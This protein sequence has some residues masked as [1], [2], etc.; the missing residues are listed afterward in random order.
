MASTGTNY[1]GIRLRYCTTDM[2]RAELGQN[3][4]GSQGR[5]CWNGYGKALFDSSDFM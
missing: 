3:V 1:I 5:G 4:L 2:N